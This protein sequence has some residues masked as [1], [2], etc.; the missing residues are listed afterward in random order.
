MTDRYVASSDNMISLIQFFLIQLNIFAVCIAQ[1]DFL[2]VP[3][4]ICFASVCHTNTMLDRSC[5]FSQTGPPRWVD[6]VAAR[7]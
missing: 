3:D 1:L 7:P 4:V 6:A 2:Y 5:I